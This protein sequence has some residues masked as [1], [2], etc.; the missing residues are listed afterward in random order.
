MRL[1]DVIAFARGVAADFAQDDVLSL[2]AAVAF[3]TA[4]S[5]AP[6]VLLLVSVG[7]LLG[8]ETKNDLLGLFSE[9]L[10]PRAADVASGV[11]HASAQDASS[12]KPWWH[13]ALSSAGLVLTASAVFGQLQASLNRMW[14]VEA[15]IPAKAAGRGRLTVVWFS[16]WGWLRKRLISMGMV[17]VVLFILLVSLVVSAVLGHLVPGGGEEL[18]ARAIE[19]LAS[20]LVATLLFA[21]IF[22]FLPDAHINW[23]H[24]WLGAL[25]TAAL[26]N[27][28]KLALALYIDKGGVGRDY[29]E[30]VGGLIALL[31]WVYYS[32]V[33]LLLGAEITQR[34]ARD[35]A[36]PRRGRL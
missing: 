10:G 23:R 13:T 22:K 7:G 28:G 11:V 24:V 31:V 19:F 9:Q 6:L 8:D 27:A 32:S 30:A 14:D 29:G 5:F 26:F 34:L 16:A 15:K 12:P 25:V 33:V 1:R 2:A 20:V 3:Y 36:R 4:L 18:A 17:L 21:A 35:P